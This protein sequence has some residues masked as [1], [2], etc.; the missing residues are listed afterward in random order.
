MLEKQVTWYHVNLQKAYSESER[1]SVY[2]INKDTGVSQNTIRRY[3][4]EGGYYVKA[5][6]TAVVTIAE[7]LGANWKDFVAEVKL[8]KGINPN[9]DDESDDE[10]PSPTKLSNSIIAVT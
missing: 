7:Y 10:I 6:P 2:R 3:I 1:P 4:R 9:P 5:I 8:G